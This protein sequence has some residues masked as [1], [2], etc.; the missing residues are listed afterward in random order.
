LEH[1]ERQGDFFVQRFSIFPRFLDAEWAWVS[2]AFEGI[3]LMF[4]KLGKVG[5]EVYRNE[6]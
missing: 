5:G 3:F 6:S 4:A 1:G 2:P